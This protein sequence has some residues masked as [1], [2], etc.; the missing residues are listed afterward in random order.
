MASLDA[1]R[2][3][4]PASSSSSSSAALQVDAVTKSSLLSTLTTLRQQLIQ[5]AADRDALKKENDKLKATNEKLNYRCN[6]LVRMLNEEE[7]KVEELS[8]KK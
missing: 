5:E 3:A 7:K 1:G 6:H 8:K 4:V 2:A